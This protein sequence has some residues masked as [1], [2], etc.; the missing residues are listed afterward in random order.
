MAEEGSSIFSI[1]V[2]LFKTLWVIAKIWLISIFRFF[3]PSSEKNI[4]KKVILITGGG[5]GIGRIMACELAAKGAIIVSWDVKEEWNFET[6]NL[7]EKLGGIFKPFTVNVRD[8]N[9]VILNAERVLA[10]I[11]PV[12][13]LVNNAGVVSGQLLTNLTEE[14]IRRTFEVNVLA[15]FWTLQ[16]FLPSMIS[17]GHGHI[18]SIASIAGFVGASSLSD[19]CSSK[20][21]AV[22]LHE[23]LVNELFTQGHTGINTT[24]VCPFHITT[25]LFDGM[26]ARFIPSLEPEYVAKRIVMAILTNQRQVMIGRD[27]YILPYLKSIMPVD[28]ITHLFKF[29]GDGKAMKNFVGRS[30]KSK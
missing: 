20:F 25:G 5:N 13:I 7:V 11:G 28:A 23:S 27:M 18:V 3:V 9:S 6:Q 4:E 15:H 10:E 30:N 8:R 12:D 24:L 19:Y 26:K 17:R 29:M 14:N 21:A 16:A 1:L 22:G 2:D